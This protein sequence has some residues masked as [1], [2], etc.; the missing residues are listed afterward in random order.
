MGIST[1]ASVEI[2]G[3]V[4]LLAFTPL[5][6]SPKGVHMAALT[7]HILTPQLSLPMSP[8]AL[9][10]TIWPVYSLVML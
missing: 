10:V 8:P 7:A 6:H 1:V 9:K 3:L 2:L 4:G 5:L